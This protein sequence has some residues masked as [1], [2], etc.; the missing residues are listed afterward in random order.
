VS[1]DV[2]VIVP[3][4]NAARWLPEA[5]GSVRA[6]D[7]PAAIVVVD[8]GSTDDTPRVLADLAGDPA[9]RLTAV[10]IANGGPAVARNRG[11]AEAATPLIAFLDVDDLWPA[12]RLAWQCA[13]LAADARTE[14]V[15]GMVQVRRL[16][17]AERLWAGRIFA[18]DALVYPHLGAGLYRRS[19][20]DR[21][22]P[23]DETM[24]IGEDTDWFFR[25][26][27]A[28]AR[29][30]VKARTAMIYRLHDANM[31]G[32]HRATEAAFARVLARKLARARAAGGPRTLPSLADF[33]ELDQPLAEG[34]GR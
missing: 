18:A 17:E 23:F 11:L 20:L 4:Y 5:I 2:T 1:P 14:A 29:F 21:I 34:G 27:E 22:G 13:R 24:R 12:D 15:F 19:L 25:A 3:A 9:N 28:E 26:Y 30:V 10:R 7:V 6:Q 32:D 16:P 31:T 33:L 8:D